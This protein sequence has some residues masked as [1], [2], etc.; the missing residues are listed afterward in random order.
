MG[1]GVQHQGP[2]VCSQLKYT[3]PIVQR[4][5]WASGPLLVTLN[6]GKRN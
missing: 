3:V 1:V 4:A 2:D 6:V 5:G